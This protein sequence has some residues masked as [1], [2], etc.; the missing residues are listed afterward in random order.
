MRS[1][2]AGFTL[3]ELLVVIAI[4]GIL[5]ALLLPA[6]Q[7]ARE[8]ARRSQCNNNLKQMALAVHNYESAT[9]HFPPGGGPLPTHVN[10]NANQVCFPGPGGSPNSSACGVQR[11]SPQA[12]ILAYIE[13]AGKADQWDF[14]YDVNGAFP[15]NTQARLTDV[16][17]YLCPSDPSNTWFAGQGRSN[18]MACIG[19]N[20]QPNRPAPPSTS[21]W[22]VSTAGIFNTEFAT[23]QWVDFSNVPRPIRMNDVLDG[24]SSTALFGET[25]RGFVA[26]SQTAYT[27][28]L[29]AHDLVQVAA[30]V[31]TSMPPS[32]ACVA[33]PST[34][35]GTVFRYSGL[36]Y[37]RSLA[38]VSFYTHTKVPNDKTIDCSDTAGG[39]IT[40]RSYHPGIVNV[41]FADGA[42]KSINSTISLTIWRNLGSRA[43]GTPAQVP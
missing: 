39:H 27:P 16:P 40:A 43:D 34:T 37:W 30:A 8:A 31:A 17:S 13:Q 38:W 28:A 1:R 3:V 5:I 15:G 41:A 42:V 7:A 4:I 6:V 10:G 32:G 25:K 12:L 11:P 35:T 18:Y 33:S 22:T 24:T 23:R 9:K 21:V 29:E 20:P 36:Q 19:Q 14:R 2:F 26:G